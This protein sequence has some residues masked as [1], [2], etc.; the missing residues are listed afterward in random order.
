M[1]WPP[2]IENAYLPWWARARDIVMTLL[3]WSLLVWLLR[4]LFI[5]WI[6]AALDVLGIE[7]PTGPWPTG[8]L[9]R[10]TVPFLV[11]VALLIVWLVLFLVVRWQLLTDTR[12]AASQPGPLPDEEQTR[13]FGISPAVRNELQQS[14]I[15]TVS[16]DGGMHDLRV[17]RIS[18]PAKDVTI[19]SSPAAP[20]SDWPGNDGSGD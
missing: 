6:Y 13:A 1:R 8:K 7:H 16:M 9:M 20:A 19:D 5:V 18:T 15:V 11:L 3:A 10:D 14:R 4:G 17:E 12:A 2:I